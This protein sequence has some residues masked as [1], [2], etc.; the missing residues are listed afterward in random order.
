MGGMICKADYDRLR[1]YVEVLEA[2]ATDLEHLSSVMP[3]NAISF[4]GD[5]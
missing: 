5:C 4:I 1:A 2:R 3:S